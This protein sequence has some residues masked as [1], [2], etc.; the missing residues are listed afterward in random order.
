MTTYAYTGSGPTVLASGQPLAPADTTT[1]VNPDEQPDSDLI[2]SGDLYPLPY[3]DEPTPDLTRPELLA[4]AAQRGITV[5]ARAT[6]A[7][8]QSLLNEGAPTTEETT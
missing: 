8:I 2:A 6:K 1:R 4:L 5:P 7:D 3:L